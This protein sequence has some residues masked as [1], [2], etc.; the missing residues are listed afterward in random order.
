M[1]NVGQIGCVLV[2]IVHIFSCVYI[3]MYIYIYTHTH[4]HKNGQHEYVD[5]TII[6]PLLGLDFP[7]L[8]PGRHAIPKRAAGAHGQALADLTGRCG[9]EVY[10]YFFIFYFFGGGRGGVL[11]EASR[12]EVQGCRARLGTLGT[13]VGV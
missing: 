1:A 13:E 6:E 2:P 12:V 10:F 4:T 9:P 7:D 11:V 5:N 8:C 3:Y